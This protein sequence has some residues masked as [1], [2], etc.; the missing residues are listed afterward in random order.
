MFCSKCGTENADTADF[1]LKCGNSLKAT[2]G[3]ANGGEEGS[4]S[5]ELK[6][7]GSIAAGLSKRAASA[8]NEKVKEMT[9]IVKAKVV[10]ISKDMASQAKQI[11]EA[12]KEAMAESKS[13]SNKEK[14]QIYT[15]KAKSFI[16]KLIKRILQFFAAVIALA[17]IGGAYTYYRDSERDAELKKLGF[18][19]H[20]EMETLQKQGWKTRAEFENFVASNALPSAEAEMATECASL[21]DFWT[22]HKLDEKAG[23]EVTDPKQLDQGLRRMLP[24]YVVNKTT[25]EV[26]EERGNYHLKQINA[27]FEKEGTSP[28]L[29]ETY[30]SCKN[31]FGAAVI[32]KCGPAGDCSEVEDKQRKERELQKS[33]AAAKQ[34]KTNIREPSSDNSRSNTSQVAGVES[35]VKENVEHYTPELVKNENFLVE[36]PFCTEVHKSLSSTYNAAQNSLLY[37]GYK[38]AK[39]MHSSGNL[40][41]KQFPL[42]KETSEY[43]AREARVNSKFSTFISSCYK[44]G[45]GAKVLERYFSEVGKVT[46]NLPCSYF[47]T[48]YKGYMQLIEDLSD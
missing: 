2:E 10:E 36:D 24:D 48:Q 37:Y 15:A 35:Y 18:K 14:A 29:I 28:K 17:I 34:E 22:K 16:S 25:R 20:W 31:K 45:I 38:V 19:D 30:K 27:R 42:P 12:G 13:E 40:A 39:G 11:G 46:E 47:E 9:P 44:K 26:L 1:C 3:K 5:N 33:A 41:C 32:A 8:A 4:V 23:I 21:S 6:K 43:F 7:L